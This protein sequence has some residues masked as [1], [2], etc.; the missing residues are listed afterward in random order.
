MDPQLDFQLR[1]TRRQFFGLAGGGIGAAALAT[2]L[3]DDLR[4]ADGLPGLPHFA[5][6]A[7]RVIY[8]FR[9]GWEAKTTIFLRLWLWCR[10]AREGLATNRSMTA[11]G[12]A[13]FCPAN[14]RV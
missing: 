13:D 12:G 7:K 11:Y 10:R 2:L 5:P 4:A 1:L 9:S 14:T 6:T 8:L 3:S